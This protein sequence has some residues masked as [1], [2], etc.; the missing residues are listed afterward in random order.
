M[1]KETNPYRLPS[2]IVPSAYRIFLTPDLTGA[3]CSGRVEIDVDVLETVSSFALNAIELELSAATVTGQGTS[4]E[5][6]E[7]TLNEEFETATFDFESDLP[8]GPATVEI[9]FTGILND[10]LHGFYRSTYTDDAGTEHVL[11]TT[12]FEATD[13][14]RAF[15][16]WDEPAFKATYQVNLTIPSHLAAYSNSSV[17]SETDL[18]NGQRTVSFSKTMKMSTYLVAFIV[19]PFEASEPIDVRGTPVRAIYPLGKG[20]LARYALEVVEHALT[21][22]SDYFAIPYPGDKL[23]LAAIPDFAAG[24][25]EN[26]GLVTFRMTDLLIDPSVASFAEIDR[27]AL[28]IN[29]EVAHMW[30][31]DLVTMDWWEGIWL[32]EAFATFM[33][34]I[35]TDH[36]RPQWKKWVGFN[37]SRDIAFAVDGL[38]ST[39]P[40]E[41]EVVSPNDCR[42]M[43]DVLT[44]I[45]GCSVLRMLEQYLGEDTFRDGIRR[46]LVKHAYANTVTK[47]LWDALGEASGEPVATIMDTW[48]LQGGYPLVTVADG[49]ISQEPFEY[50]AALGESNIGELWQVP[51]LSRPL[52]A[53]KT[54]KQ[55]LSAKSAPLA[56]KGVAVVNAGGWGFYR[57]AYGTNE[58][59]NIAA[60]LHDLDELERAVLFSDSWAATLVGRS[61]LDGLLLLTKGLGDLDEP[62][63][64]GVAKEALTMVNRLVD[65]DGREA[66]ASVTRSLYEPLFARLGWEPIKGESEQAGELRALAI[67]LLGTYGQDEA[68]IAES[69]RRFDAN[70]LVGDLAAPVL[71][72]VVNQNRAG[73]LDECERRRKNAATPQDEQRY[74][75]SQAGFPDV[76]IAE[77]LFERCYTEVRNQDAPFVIGAM[78][79]NRVTGPTIWKKMRDR[80]D[81]SIKLF[82]TGMPARM[83]GGVN[84]LIADPSLAK[85]IRAFHVAHPVPAGQRQIEQMLD[86]MDLGVAFGERVRPTLTQTLLDVTDKEI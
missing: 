28:V 55:V 25:M 82:P 56:T 27:V 69:F 50:S 21:F 66:L 44:Y 23:D 63:T 11:A 61:T 2:T 52:G 73:D 32:N 29:H 37:P 48:I 68:I 26:L 13:A 43:F 53:T 77:D 54:T 16:C 33:E 64:W 18:G 67:Q 59:A 22:F 49:T 41:Y 45:K 12:Q 85:E 83:A 36:F 14:R 78:V 51:V 1:S 9:S 80:W 42:G 38:H 57:T 47:D 34:S 5:S 40:I 19:G 76:A 8:L 79:S 62:A 65:D 31:G 74:L 39:R 58:L 60:H 3:V 70:E 46:Y 6:S 86:R 24:A 30:F 84:A 15:P 75:F 17:A 81:E 10:Q 35:C 20:H 7:P 72:I 4:L 71:A